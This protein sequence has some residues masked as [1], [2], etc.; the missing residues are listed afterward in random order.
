V[1]E[2]HGESSGR[3]RRR[4]EP[5]IPARAQQD[6][7]QGEAIRD[8]DGRSIGRQVREIHRQLRGDEDEDG[9]ERRAEQ[10]RQPAAIGSERRH[11]AD[12]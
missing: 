10:G 7:G 5:Q 9:E 6:G 2:L 1:D 4:V 3:G 12:D 8:P 11:R